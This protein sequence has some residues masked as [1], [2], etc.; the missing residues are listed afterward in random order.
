MDDTYQKP[1]QG[2]V[3][4]DKKTK[5]S[6]PTLYPDVEYVNRTEP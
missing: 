6:V 5:N 4:S 1:E 3:T 2:T